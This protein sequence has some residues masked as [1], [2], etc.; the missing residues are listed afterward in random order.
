MCLTFA[1]KI[2]IHDS[3][4]TTSSRMSLP[5][6][7]ETSFSCKGIRKYDIIY[8]QYIYLRTGLKAFQLLAEIRS[9]IRHL[10][11]KPLLHSFRPLVRMQVKFESNSI[12]S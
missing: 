4:A 10:G 12:Y 3:N 9:N 6:L 11:G 7:P 8:L 1:L 2:L 5:F